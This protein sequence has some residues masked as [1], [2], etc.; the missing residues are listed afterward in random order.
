L[1]ADDTNLTASGDSITDVVTVVNSDL[2]NLR[3]WLTSNKHSLNVA[4]TEFML[5][6]SKPMIKNIYDFHP[7]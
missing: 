3:K 1:F 2:E 5:I 4:K 6:G 7:N